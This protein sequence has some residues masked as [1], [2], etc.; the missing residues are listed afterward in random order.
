MRYCERQISCTSSCCR[1]EELFLK[2][3]RKYLKALNFVFG[4]RKDIDKLPF[5]SDV[6]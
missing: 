6:I 1:R 5:G 2:Q 3:D 4:K